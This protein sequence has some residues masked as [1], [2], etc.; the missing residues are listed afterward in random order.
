M[1]SQTDNEVQADTTE[2]GHSTT[3]TVLYKMAL[4]TTN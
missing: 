4:T 3:Y 1:H 2:T